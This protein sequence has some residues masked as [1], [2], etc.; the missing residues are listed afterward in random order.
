MT[1]ANTPSTSIAYNGEKVPVYELETINFSEL[2]SAQPDEINKLR[3]CCEKDGFFYL[4]LDDIEGKRMLKDHQRLL[5]LMRRFFKWPDNQKEEFGLLS[6]DH[7]YDLPP[8]S[9]THTANR[10][11]ATS[12]L[13]TI[14]E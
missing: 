11:Q 13:A 9:F 14:P 7:G 3:K 5:A 6:L 2:L 10:L 12:Q 8:P 1:I 4:D